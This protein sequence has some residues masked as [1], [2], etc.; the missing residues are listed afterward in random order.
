MPTGQRPLRK[1]R[2]RP[3]AR[4]CVRILIDR[5]IDTSRARF[6]H[7]LQRLGALAPVCLPNNLV[8]RYLGGQVTLLTDA[9][10][11]GDAIDHAGCLVTHVRDVH[12][13]ET[14]GHLSQFDDLLG[15]R[16][17]PRDVEEAG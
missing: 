16:E 12:S 14:P 6:V 4:G 17:I 5:D 2:R 13:A 8:M 7:E 9:Y 11:F 10:G 3:G 1:Q 15:W